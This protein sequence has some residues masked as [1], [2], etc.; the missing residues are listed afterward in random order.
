MRRLRAPLLY[1]DCHR[2]VVRVPNSVYGFELA[3]RR[4]RN[5]S[6]SRQILPAPLVG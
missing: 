2:V 6:L 3:K 5:L 1:A 4:C